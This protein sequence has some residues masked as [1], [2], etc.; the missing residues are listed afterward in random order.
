MPCH[1]HTSISTFHQLDITPTTLVLIPASLSTY[2]YKP[3]SQQ[4][5][6]RPSQ[7]NQSPS[8][9][10]HRDP[11]SALPT[12]ETP[13]VVLGV[14]GGWESCQVLEGKTGMSVGVVNVASHVTRR[15]SCGWSWLFQTG[16]RRYG[17]GC[18]DVEKGERF[19]FSSLNRQGCRVSSRPML[20]LTIS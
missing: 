12:P 5:T 1:Y 17:T 20:S 18:S 8:P 3:N 2:S 7:R 9:S 10:H 11:S 16:E 14:I 13:Q 4:H 6:T 15:C 19:G